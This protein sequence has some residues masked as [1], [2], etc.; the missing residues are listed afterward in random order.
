MLQVNRVNRPALRARRA[1]S[2][3]APSR[4]GRTSL[5]QTS[6][7]KV[8]TLYAD[9]PISKT[10]LTAAHEDYN[11][12]VDQKMPVVNVGSIEKPSYLPVEVCQVE[13]GQPA[14]TKLSPN[15][16]REMLK[17]AVRSPAQNASS[18]VTKGMETLGLGDPINATLVRIF[19]IF[20]THPN[21]GYISNAFNVN[22]RNLVYKPTPV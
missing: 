10:D 6:L 3:L 11:I 19:L 9:F 7:S 15:Q 8:S 18:I 4:Q 14:K 21:A 22:R 17:F 5:L 16:T 20:L 13:A 1:R 12:Q 2:R